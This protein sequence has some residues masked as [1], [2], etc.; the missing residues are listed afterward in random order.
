[1]KFSGAI[2]VLGWAGAVGAWFYGVAEWIM[3]LRF[4]PSIYNV[5]I[6]V[7][8]ERL[9]GSLPE[10]E[11]GVTFKSKYVVGKLAGDGKII[12]RA[13]FKAFSLKFHIPLPLK[14]TLHQ[15]TDGI[16]F[17][18]RLPLGPVLFMGA[19][20]IAGLSEVHGRYPK[21]GWPMHFP[22]R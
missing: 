22:L 9:T 5:G 1:M 19:W 8:E 13:P 21:K 20:V 4:M 3:T 6:R 15:T 2:F 16:N 10:L 18:A 7:I 12:F 14:G 11:E 17:V